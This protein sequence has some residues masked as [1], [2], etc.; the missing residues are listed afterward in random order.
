MSEAMTVARGEWAARISTAWNK[1]VQAIFEVGEHLM[2]AKRELPHGEY[3]A[4]VESDLPFGP[5]SAQRLVSIAKD[6]RLSD[7]THVSVL[8]SA[9]GTLYELTQL[10][11]KQF[12]EGVDRGIIH[13]DMERKDLNLW[14]MEQKREVVATKVQEAA[15]LSGKYSL[16]YADPPW[17]YEN[18]PMGGTNRSIENQYPTLDLQEICALPVGNIA[19]DDCLLFMWATAPKLAECFKVLEAWEFNYRTNLVW[20]KDKIG[21]GYHARNQHELLL[22]ANRGTPPPPPISARESSVVEAPRGEHSVKPQEFYELIETMQPE[23]F[24]DPEKPV[25]IELFCRSPR[26]GWAAWGNMV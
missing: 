15:V 2:A 3:E 23:F 24:A 13:S 4:M 16:I 12:T 1:S 20:V 17:R 10:S 25:A 9:W 18:P 11:D 19:A 7:P 14:R 6:E 22:I 5:R 26:Q 21:M 8:P